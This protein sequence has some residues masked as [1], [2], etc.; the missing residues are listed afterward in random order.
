[1]CNVSRFSRDRKKRDIYITRYEYFIGI[2]VFLQYSIRRCIIDEWLG[3]RSVSE[4]VFIVKLTVI[5]E[6]Q[7]NKSGNSEV[8]K[9][10]VAMRKQVILDRI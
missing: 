9:A 3:D 1:M 5:I 6:R 7:S 8:G 4:R 10:L 2:Y